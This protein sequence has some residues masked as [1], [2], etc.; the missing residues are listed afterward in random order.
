MLNDP[1]NNITLY[2]FSQATP[3]NQEYVNQA[4][5]ETAEDYN[6]SWSGLAVTVGQI[7]QRQ[8]A[9]D[10]SDWHFYFTGVSRREMI[11]LAAR[12]LANLYKQRLP[13]RH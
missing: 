8:C 2:T 7:I 11:H 13:Y 9:I 6:L 4:Q 12:Q 3:V 1:I 5:S 10:P